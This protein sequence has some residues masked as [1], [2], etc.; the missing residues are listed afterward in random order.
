MQVKGG[1]GSVH[2]LATRLGAPGV[3][4]WGASSRQSWGHR[5]LR[6]GPQ[7]THAAFGGPLLRRVGPRPLEPAWWMQAPL[8]GQLALDLIPHLGH[9]D[10]LIGKVGTQNLLR[11]YCRTNIL[12]L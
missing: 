4:A 11:A 3:H 7:H 6:H 1:V 2:S 8:W 10:F 9:L 12:T 5:A